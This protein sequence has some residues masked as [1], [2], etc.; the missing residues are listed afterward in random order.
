MINPILN[1]DEAEDIRDR[2]NEVIKHVNAN[3]T[4]WPTGTYIIPGQVIGIGSSATATGGVTAFVPFF[5]PRPTQISNVGIYIATLGDAAARI[6]CA[7]FD[8]ADNDDGLPLNLVVDGGEADVGSGATGAIRDLWATP[9][10]LQRGKYWVQW[11][12][13]ATTTGV[14]VNRISFAHKYVPQTSGISA[15]VQRYFTIPHSYG[16]PVTPNVATLTPQAGNEGIIP[17]LKAA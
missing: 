11:Q 9:A 15:G 7:I 8:S 2:L 12:I 17:Y 4:P 6:R 3:E 13:K 1:H 14:T 10:T 5:C 16:P